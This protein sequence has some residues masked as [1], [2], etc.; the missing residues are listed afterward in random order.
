MGSVSADMMLA[1]DAWGPVRRGIPLTGSWM[2]EASTHIDL[3][4]L[5]ATAS[6]Y[7]VPRPRV[8]TARSSSAPQRGMRGLRR[9]QSAPLGPMQGRGAHGTSRVSLVVDSPLRTQV[10]KTVLDF[11][12]PGSASLARSRTS[13]PERP[14]PKTAWTPERRHKTT[15]T[16]SV[17]WTS[18]DISECCDLLSQL[19]F[20]QGMTEEELR[21]IV[22]S[23]SKRVVGRYAVVY[24]EG[25]PARG[26]PLYIV[27]PSP[28]RVARSSASGGGD[29]HSSRPHSATTSP[30][31]SRRS[32]FTTLARSS[33]GAGPQEACDMFGMESCTLDSEERV[34]LQTAH[35]VDGSA[36]LLV[37]PPDSLPVALRRKATCLCNTQ[38]LSG[39]TG[40]HPLTQSTKLSAVV[41]HMRLCRRAAGERIVTKG[42]RVAGIHI[43]VAGTGQLQDEDGAA[44]IELGPTSPVS[45]AIGLEGLLAWAAGG[46]ARAIYEWTVVAKSA[47]TLVFIPLSAYSVLSSAMAAAEDLLTMADVMKSSI[48]R[49]LRRQRG[50]QLRADE[51]DALREASRRSSWHTYGAS[52]EMRMALLTISKTPVSPRRGSH[53]HGTKV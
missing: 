14:L 29:T 47:S 22:A 1:K 13:D 39:A 37:L 51:F 21:P 38:L 11:R 19:S 7:R 31:S 34:R 25:A 30:R 50:A 49:A 15:I 2:S 18:G 33:A 35:V 52:I 27:L 26:Q 44:A 24:R 36:T 32:S 41:P 9:P 23:A 5:K 12:R 46:D 4:A 17:T 10:G 20:F 3:R 8:M 6:P 42:A 48:S 45:A 28:G 53:A 16:D 43:F 40:V